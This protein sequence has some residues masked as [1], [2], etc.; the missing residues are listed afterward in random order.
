M[1]SFLFCSTEVLQQNSIDLSLNIHDKKDLS[2]KDNNEINIFQIKTNTIDPDIFLWN[3]IKNQKMAIILVF[4]IHVACLIIQTKFITKYMDEICAFDR[5]K[6]Q[7]K[8]TQYIKMWALAVLINALCDNFSDWAC[9]TI[10]RNNTHNVGEYFFKRLL[11]NEIEFFIDKAPGE[12]LSKLSDLIYNLNDIVTY[13]FDKFISKTTDLAVGLYLI[14]NSLYILVVYLVYCLLVLILFHYS[15]ILNSKIYKSIYECNS[16]QNSAFLDGFSNLI[17]RNVYQTEKKELEVYRKLLAKENKLNRR[18][19]FYSLAEYCLGTFFYVIFTYIT[20][21]LYEKHL[22]KEETTIKTGIFQYCYKLPELTVKMFFAFFSLLKSYKDFKNNFTV[23]TNQYIYLRGDEI[24]NNIDSIELQNVYKT[25]ENNTIINGVNLLINKKDK[26]ILKGST[27][28]GKTTLISLICGLILPTKGSVYMNNLKI[29]NYKKQSILKNFVYVPQQ[30]VLY[31][32]SIR[33]N[34]T[35]GLSHYEEE[36]FIKACYLANVDVFVNKKE[37]KYE[38]NVGNSGGKLS[39]GER[40]RI[41]LARAFL[42]ILEINSKIAIF[43][44]VTSCLDEET[45]YFI[46]SNIKKEFDD[47][48]IIFISHDKITENIFKTAIIYKLDKGN[49]SQVTDKTES[50]R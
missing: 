47:L 38:T 27:G 25:Y 44:E 37:E 36:N 33:N 43:D 6:P 28:A 10:I 35:I 1:I 5:T 48:L 30:C 20:L 32:D 26:I 7:G 14:C 13:I 15:N 46:L 41:L 22:P 19:S 18:A 17:S 40:Q 9:E 34:I 2:K 4:M 8:I 24:L 50:I 45:A 42:R 29:L 39:G 12:L 31:N 3:I 23:F 11:N 16:K 49:I 21:Y